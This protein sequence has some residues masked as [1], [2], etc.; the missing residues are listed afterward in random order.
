MRTTFGH[1]LSELGGSGVRECHV[2]HMSDILESCYNIAQPTG[3]H[4]F[5]TE[6]TLSVYN[7]INNK[8]MV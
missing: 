6:D 4:V 8:S 3:P 2:P 5:S 7:L 1:L